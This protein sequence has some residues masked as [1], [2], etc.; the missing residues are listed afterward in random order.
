M[1]VTCKLKEI[2]EAFYWTECGIELGCKTERSQQ[3]NP[4][5]FGIDGLVVHSVGVCAHQY[6][7]SS[8]F[9]V[10]IDFPGWCFS[11]P[12]ARMWVRICFAMLDKLLLLQRC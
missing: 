3:A 9:R 10:G 6:S 11:M 8:P 1:K 7:L 2:S 12:G 4:K 5:Y